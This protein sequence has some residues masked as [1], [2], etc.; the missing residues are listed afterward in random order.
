MKSLQN[1]FKKESIVTEIKGNSYF[2][3]LRTFNINYFDDFGIDKHSKLINKY[4]INDIFH[5][6]SFS[7]LESESSIISHALSTSSSENVRTGLSL[8][9]LVPH[10]RTN[11]CSCIID[12]NLSL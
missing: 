2:R 10:V 7:N 6:M 12:F 8:I 5:Y 11:I 4:F 9:D 3:N 1:S